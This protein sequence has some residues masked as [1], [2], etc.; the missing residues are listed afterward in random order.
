[1]YR[2]PVRGWRG[3]SQPTVYKLLLIARASRYSSARA[4]RRLIAGW[5]MGCAVTLT[6]KVRI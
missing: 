5:H 6:I 4:M 1:M 3:A 2:R